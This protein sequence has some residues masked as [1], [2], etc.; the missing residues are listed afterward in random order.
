VKSYGGRRK[1]TRSGNN[2]L[3]EETSKS[4]WDE[5]QL[6]DADTL[7]FAKASVGNEWI[8]NMFTTLHSAYR[9][10]VQQLG[11]RSSLSSLAEVATY[12][13]GTWTYL[14]ETQT[15]MPPADSPSSD[16]PALTLD[17]VLLE[18][19]PPTHPHMPLLLGYTIA[20]F[21]DYA[22]VIR[23]LLP[24]LILMTHTVSRRA[25]IE[26]AHSLFSVSG[27]GWEDFSLCMALSRLIGREDEYLLWLS[28]NMS[29]AFIQEGGLGHLLRL[30]RDYP[31]LAPT[32]LR[33][34]QLCTPKKKKQ[35]PVD[36]DLES[37]ITHLVQ[38]ICTYALQTDSTKHLIHIAAAL[39]SKQ[40]PFPS[41]ALLIHLTIKNILPT[42]SDAVLPPLLHRKLTYTPLRQVIPPSALKAQITF[43]MTQPSL[44]TLAIAIARDWKDHIDY[45]DDE[46]DHLESTAEFLERVEREYL[47]ETEG[48]MWRFEDVLAEWIG[49]WPDG[50]EMSS[51]KIT[52]TQQYLPVEEEEE[53][54]EER[55]EEEDEFGGSLVK[56][57][58]PRS[59]LVMETPVPMKV[60]DCRTERRV[61]LSRLFKLSSIGKTVRSARTKEL[62]MEARDEESH[63]FLKRLE[64]DQRKPAFISP[65]RTKKSPRK[66]VIESDDDDGEAPIYKDSE[67]EYMVMETIK[68]SPRKRRRFAQ[69]DSESDGSIY[70]ESL[71]E[72][73]DIENLSIQSEPDSDLLTT[74]D[75]DELSISITPNRSALQGIAINRTP[76]KSPHHRNSGRVVSKLLVRESSPVILDDGSDDEL[77]L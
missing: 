32:V 41:L 25:T 60:S 68:P 40:T 26:L 27:A 28:R 9:I 38:L 77:A 59:G 74:S 14:Y 1:R 35:T 65:N 16:E 67:L 72:D 20:L 21:D 45:D 5:A 46:A 33:A 36:P 39:P 37:T 56:R 63:S 13:L 61:V 22:E 17:D 53:E 44:S 8:A 30:G 64:A 7:K 76:G 54:E 10:F 31:S 11:L 69:S 48:V 58:V 51:S 24:T 4:I 29:L 6:T 70:Q 52:R 3:E 34:I 15:D 43:L 49:E 62:S 66:R 71:N 42:Y 19:L 47:T 12:T 75:V 18:Y 50:K 73:T 55:G 57:F 2:I 23:P